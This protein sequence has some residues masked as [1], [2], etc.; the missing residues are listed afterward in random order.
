MSA[1]MDCA[2]L[3]EL[4]PELVVDSLDGELRADALAHLALCPTCRTEVNELADT[5]DAL[6]LLAPS[7]EPP[8]G[9][10][11]RV[12]D[13]MSP[14]A[15][16]PV[17]I[18]GKR[19]RWRT[20]H[21]IAAI[22]AAVALAAAGTVAVEQHQDGGSGVALNARTLRTVRM[23]GMDK[24]SVGDAYVSTGAN[25]W[26]LVSLD[27]GF[28][29]R[30]YRLVGVRADGTVVDVGGMRPVDGQWAWAGRFPTAGTLVE[31]RVVDGAGA[32]VCRGTL[33]TTTA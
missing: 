30:S 6:T 16:A 13:A 20:G 4:A 25:P 21:V 18:E 1:P 15:P 3:H 24:A 14:P 7:A 10:I 28:T 26:I 29:E 32:L 33:P 23:I 22:A 17:P 2:T 8:P 11:D 9:F 5:A 12:L 27:Y 31:L 19:R